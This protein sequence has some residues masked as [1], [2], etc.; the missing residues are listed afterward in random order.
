MRGPRNSFPLAGELVPGSSPLGCFRI[1]GLSERIHVCFAAIIE[2]GHTSSNAANELQA[3]REIAMVNP[4][5]G[6]RE[7]IS[8]PETRRTES[9]P[10]Q[11][12]VSAF[13]K[14]V[15]SQHVAVELE[16]K[17]NFYTQGFCGCADDLPP[18]N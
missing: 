11:A 1:S 8:S 6:G 9:Q 3:Y 12:L 14:P 7:S 16:R 4:T 15:R 5:G 17:V 18:G 13:A 10:V 2:A